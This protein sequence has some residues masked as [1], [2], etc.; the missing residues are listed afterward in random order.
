M[1]ID[2]FGH[3]VHKRLRVS[4]VCEFKNKALLRSDNGDF[5]LQS[6]RLKGVVNPSSPDDVVN[7]Q[8]V[9][10]LV[11]N[12]YDK[13]HLD[14]IFE[15]INSQISQLFNQLRINFYT[16]KELEGILN[17]FNNG[18]RTSRERNP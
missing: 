11:Q 10:E 17:N 4:E 7:K 16:K 15:I 8:Y 18:Q 6:S 1:N 2:K 5:D 12:I 13:K 9:D 14:S 3:H